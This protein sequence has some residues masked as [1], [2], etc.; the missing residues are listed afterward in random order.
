M[1]PDGEFLGACS[2]FYSVMEN[3]HCS[4]PE[5]EMTFL[6]VLVNSTSSHTSPPPKPVTE[7]DLSLLR[8]HPSHIL[9]IG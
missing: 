4:I 1:C 6:L 8:W 7:P 9:N 3:Q 2:D 5:L